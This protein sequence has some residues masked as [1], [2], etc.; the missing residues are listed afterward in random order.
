MST[1]WGL[2]SMV[3]LGLLGLGC[4]VP[5]DP[6]ARVVADE[7][8]PYDLLSSTTAS[9]RS[10]E[11]QGDETS[12]CLVIDSTVLAVGRD[13]SGASPLSSLSQLVLAGPTQGEAQL[14]LRSALATPNMVTAVVPL[15]S[16]AQ[17]QLGSEFAELS[18]DQ[19]LLAVAQI[20]CTLTTQ[21][22]VARVAF[23]LAGRDVE[24]PVQ[25]GSLVSRPVE[26]SDY[27]ELIAN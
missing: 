12:I 3:L 14:G 26:R 4:G 11:A 18:A 6:E 10:A 23:S 9:V 5:H 24:V 8:V 2:V 25:D 17:V 7:D 1:T 21:P 20:T 27:S 16:M 15:G 19:Q 22:G 13:R